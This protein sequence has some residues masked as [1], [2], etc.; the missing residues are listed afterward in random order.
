MKRK[1]LTCIKHVIINGKDYLWDDLSQEE[2][3]VISLKLNDRA[4][5]SI[6]YKPV[7]EDEFNKKKKELEDLCSNEE[8]K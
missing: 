5:R 6:G 3:A 2:K 4:L 1:E 7:D 8:L